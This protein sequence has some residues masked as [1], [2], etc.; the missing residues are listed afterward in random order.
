VLA[1]RPQGRIFGSSFLCF[2]GGYTGGQSITKT[3]NVPGCPRLSW[4]RSLD[5][6]SRAPRAA[7]ASA[8]RPCATHCPA[9]ILMPDAS[10]STNA[11][12]PFRHS[13]SSRPRSNVALEE[14]SE[15]SRSRRKLSAAVT[16]KETTFILLKDQARTGAHQ[17]HDQH[18]EPHQIQ[19]KRKSVGHSVQIQCSDLLRKTLWHA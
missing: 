17:H 11:R 2:R 3:L 12:A 8:R 9:R 4:K 14:I 10:A 1:R 16:K 7:A 6:Q 5:A 19:K 13:R 15:L 18:C